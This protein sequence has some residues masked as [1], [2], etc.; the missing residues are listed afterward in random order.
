M[1]GAICRQVANLCKNKE[2]VTKFSE[3]VTTEKNIYLSNP[4]SFCP[5]FL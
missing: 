1:T 4:V 5:F 2:R 3:V